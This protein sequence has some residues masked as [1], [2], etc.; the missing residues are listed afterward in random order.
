M[1][2]VDHVQKDDLVQAAIVV[3]TFAY[4]TAMRPEKLPRKAGLYNSG[5]LN[6]GR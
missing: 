2:T 1:D 6:G 3:A 4:D 5:R